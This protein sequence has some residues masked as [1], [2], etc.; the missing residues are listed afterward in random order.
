MLCIA[1]YLL[2]AY[3]RRMPILFSRLFLNHFLCFVAVMKI[4][5][6]LQII[7]FNC[8]VSKTHYRRPSMLSMDADTAQLITL[9]PN[10]E[11]FLLELIA[12]W[13]LLYSVIC[14]F[15][16]AFHITFVCNKNPNNF[17][18]EKTTVHQPMNLLTENRL[19]GGAT[20]VRH[21]VFVY[22]F[23]CSWSLVIFVRD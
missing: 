6:L 19:L 12:F 7:V 9:W 13:R 1:V 8:L 11:C 2:L 15:T 14:L 18:G 16:Q 22:S 5:W 3:N 4:V 10:K 17:W 21:N 20:L 23:D